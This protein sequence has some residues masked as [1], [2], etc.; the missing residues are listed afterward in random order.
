MAQLKDSSTISSNETNTKELIWHNGNVSK[1]NILNQSEENKNLGNLIHI[2]DNPNSYAYSSSDE[3][4]KKVSISNNVAIISAVSEK[5]EEGSNS[6]VVYLIDVV[7]NK[8]LHTIVNPNN[9]GGDAE[10]DFGYDVSIDGNY[11]IASALESDTSGTSSGVVYVFDVYTGELLRTLENPSTYS[12][13]ASD[14]FGYSIEL[15]DNKC[16]VGAPYEDDAGGTSSGAAYIFDITTGELLHTL[17]NPNVYG[18]SLSDYFGRAVAIYGDKCIM[19]GYGEDEVDAESSGKAYIF[20]VNTGNLLHTIDNPNAYGTPST[21]Y[22]GYSVSIYKNKCIVGAPN[23]DEVSGLS[24]GKAYIFDVNSGELLLTLGGSLS[25]EA[26]FGRASALSD[27]I[28]VIA[29]P[30]EGNGGKV[31]VYD[32]NT[33]VLLNTIYNFTPYNAGGSDNFG[34][35]V[36][37]DGSKCV[38]GA[39]LE[40]D[41][42]G[43]SSGAAYYVKVDNSL[44]SEHI[45]ET[46]I[47]LEEISNLSN[48]IIANAYEQIVAVQ[49]PNAYSISAGD[50]F[51]QSVAVDNNTCIVGTF[52]ESSDE[53]GGDSGLVY[54]IDFYTGQVRYI[55]L[56][57]N[58]YGTAYLDFFG[59]KVAI[60]GSRFVV[61][62]YGEDD[63]NGTKSGKAYIF[64]VNDG[65]LLH[66]LVNPNDYGTSASDEFGRAMDISHEYCIVGA[67]SEDEVS[68]NNSGVVYVFN[69][70]TGALLRTIHNPNVYSTVADDNFGRSIS[71][72]GDRCIVGAP[73]EDDATAGQSGAAYIFNISTGELLHTLVNPNDYGTSGGDYFGEVVSI[74]GDYC[75]VGAPNEDDVDGLDSGKVYVFSVKS[76]L[77]LHTLNNPNPTGSHAYDYFG[78]S[79]SLS[80][81]ICIV[82]AYGEDVGGE[83][84]GSVYA[85]NVISGSLIKII[86]NPSVYSTVGGDKFGSALD[87]SNGNFI[88]G[89]PEERDINYD[90]SGAIYTFSTTS[91][92]KMSMLMNLI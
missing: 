64:N 3:F 76:G 39:Y 72:S 37:V 79:L 26:Y 69:V 74:S 59:Y 47:V 44:L 27:T 11:C 15:Y 31:Y 88:V 80:N 57:P 7:S 38:I 91:V 42:G 29:A 89:V 45:M 46:A 17:V 1:L 21:D 85:F 41:T 75:V 6:G 35:D 49:N 71:I 58:S 70:I 20:S 48:D 36:S 73:N 86:E 52:Y 50:K 33:G 8:I 60:S 19:N 10:D 32:V 77:L 14:M 40:D 22:F 66:T 67:Q 34:C 63:A 78:R 28:C 13:G 53:Q 54:I 68:G 25:A 61:G 9:Y 84:S 12:T 56:N 2:I 16:I 23:E 24:A 62:A 30:Y 83:Y 81:N 90:D 51:G 5:S 18:T 87:L 82:G 65:S 43:T 92:S 55:V 4:G